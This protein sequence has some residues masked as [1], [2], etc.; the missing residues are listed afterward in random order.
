MS[1]STSIKPGILEY[2]SLGNSKV[3]EALCVLVGMLEEGS[4]LPKEGLKGR[5]GQ[6]GLESLKCYQI[7]ALQKSRG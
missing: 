7:T 6:K 2:A 1:P 4:L 5:E 3:H